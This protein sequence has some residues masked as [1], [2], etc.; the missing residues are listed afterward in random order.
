MT[1][2]CVVHL[3]QSFGCGGLERVIANLISHPDSQRVN[4]VVVS[5]SD[6]T[7]FKYALPDNVDVVS[8]NKKPGKDF[9]AHFRIFKLLKKYRAA[10][11]HTYN[12]GTIEYHLIAKLAG[13]R[14]HVH[15]D[16]G[17][18][19]DH[20]EGKNAKHNAFRRLISH[21]IDNYIVVSDDLKKWVTEVVGVN[22][23]KVRFVFNGVEIH[24]HEA[25]KPRHRKQLNTVIVGRLAK[26]KNHI[27]LIEALSHIERTH[28]E[29][30]VNCT[31]VGEGAERGAIEQALKS[32]LTH[33]NRVT[34]AGHQSD[35]N[36]FIRK[37][38]ALILSSDYEA[39]PMTVLE[40][41]SLSTPVVCP[42]VGGVEDFITINEAIL[43]EKH[44]AQ[45]LAEGIIKLTSIPYDDEVAMVER[46]HQKV[47]RE[48]GLDKMVKTYTDMYTN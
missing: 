11:L 37:A 23:E 40:A 22:K 34:L 48:Y 43:T 18:G 20:P 30:T 3:T 1:K 24:P 46:A 28:P 7:S 4:H 38:D 16:H 45:S 21:I 19:G 8:V 10:T 2:E 9:G 15:A 41:M 14:K 12:F 36:T 17:L 47:S 42:K 25:P 31:I 44:D 39:M 35:V 13:V 32:K 29:L 5:L 26:V 33:P 6:D 27:R